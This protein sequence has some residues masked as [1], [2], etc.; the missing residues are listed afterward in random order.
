VRYDP[1]VEVTH[2]ESASWRERLVRRYRYG[3]SAAPL[4]L[5]H[6]SSITHLAVRP[7]PLLATAAVLARRP[8]LAAA[9]VAATAVTT[10]RALR[11]AGASDL[12]E[13]RATASVLAG[14]WLGT[15]RYATQFAAPLLLE[16]RAHRCGH[17]HSNGP[18][19]YTLA[20]LA[21]APPLVDWFRSRPQVSAPRYVAGRLADDAAY[22][23][24][25]YAGCIHHRTAAPL[26]PSLSR[27]S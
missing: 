25:V 21:I 22:G 11:D 13:T 19:A 2:D 27:R 8:T 10:R 4:A 18:S 16:R 1:S 24:G 17:R 14:A 5:R 20:A 23:A 9:A 26:L 15:G 12:G 6:P 3:T 7:L